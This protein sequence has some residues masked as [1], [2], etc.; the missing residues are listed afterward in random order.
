VTRNEVRIAKNFE[1]MEVK[2]MDASDAA[3]IILTTL[4]LTWWDRASITDCRRV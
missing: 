4:M 2:I 3:F 1:S